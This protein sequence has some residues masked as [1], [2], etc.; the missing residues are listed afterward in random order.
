M[1]SRLYENQG[2]YF[3]INVCL[4]CLNLCYVEKK[5]LNTLTMLI[6]RSIAPCDRKLFLIFFRGWRS[7]RC[8]DAT[9]AKIKNLQ[10]EWMFTSDQVR[11]EK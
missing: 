11:T 7:G 5:D 3:Q 9:A 10:E 2:L 6:C 4:V 1:K 8:G